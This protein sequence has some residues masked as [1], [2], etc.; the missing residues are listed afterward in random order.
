MQLTTP[1]QISLE[2]ARVAL[3][4]GLYVK[5]TLGMGRAAEMAGLARPACQ[6]VMARRRVPVDYSLADLSED[7]AAIQSK[8][9]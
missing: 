4:L 1:D 7:M 3:A 5:G 9:A 8:A 6:Q 2:E